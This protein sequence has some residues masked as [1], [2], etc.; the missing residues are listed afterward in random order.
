MDQKITLL[1]VDDEEFNLEIIS[2][3]LEDMPYELVTASNGVEAWDALALEPNRYSA[4]LLD[5]MMPE[6][7]GIQVLTR[8]KN[9]ADLRNLPVI[10]QTAA[11]SKQ[12]ISEGLRC[13]AYYYLTKPFDE[14]VLK[15]IV[16]AAI[17]DF[18]RIQALQDQVRSG[19]DVV[20][21]LTS[22]FFTLQ[23]LEEARDLSSFLANSF[24]D[25]ERVV[26]GLSELLINAIE[27]GNLGIMYDDKTQ[28]VTKGTWQNEVNRR[29]EQI[30]NKDKF[31]EVDFY[32]DKQSIRIKIS[33]CGAGFDWE[34]Y[35]EFN[36]DRVYDNHGR[37]I[38]MANKLSFDSVEYIGRGNQVEVTVIL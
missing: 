35:L 17:D 23:R 19:A 4:V 31:V 3:Y 38:A 12:D 16:A 29:L 1:V 9:S 27:H 18:T 5:R 36:T 7:D 25:P 26:S 21:M 22:G 20:S 37:G 11:A 14:E 8:M 2:E 13:G 10:L 6:M 28:L 34:N 32:K 24:P 33:D 30:E 15:S